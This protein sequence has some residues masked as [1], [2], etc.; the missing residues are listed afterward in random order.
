MFLFLISG[1][2]QAAF[3]ANA[4]MLCSL[5]LAVLAVGICAWRYI[6]KGSV[7][8]SR[9]GLTLLLVWVFAGLIFAIARNIA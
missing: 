9:Y 4:F 6:D 7:N 8:V 5:P 2:V 3:R 1:D